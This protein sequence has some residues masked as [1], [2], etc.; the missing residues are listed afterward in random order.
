MTN[1]TQFPKLKIFISIYIFFLIFPFLFNLIIEYNYLQNNPYPFQTNL[2]N[3]NKFLGILLIFQI[4]ITGILSP[5][6]EEV[7]QRYWIVDK[8]IGTNI[9][10]II[11]F[12]F[13]S[14]ALLFF[15]KIFNP[16]YQNIILR[17]IENFNGFG[18]LSFILA[19]FIL[20]YF[21]PIC[22]SII[23]YFILRFID[24]KEI[25][26]NNIN[27]FIIKNHIIIALIASIYFSISH[28]EFNYDVLSLSIIISGLIR[29]CLGYI[30]FMIMNITTLKISILFHSLKNFAVLLGYTIFWKNI[31]AKFYSAS[32]LSVIIIITTLLYKELNMIK[33]N[34]K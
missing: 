19:Q 29:F 10:L 1:F 14:Q 11:L 17:I 6:L 26:N 31:N 25:I 27:N 18:P 2:F 21:I 33:L 28:L 15:I 16:T 4:F 7:V 13:L 32:I 22:I 23:L 8:I 12:T 9:R 3:S 34:K 24:S 5:I 30:L 20:M